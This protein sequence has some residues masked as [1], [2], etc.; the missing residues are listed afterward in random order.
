M[1]QSLIADEISTQKEQWHGRTPATLR[2]E[3]L[4]MNI[5]IEQTNPRSAPGDGINYFRQDTI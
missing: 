3:L 1:V 2:H 5:L 4:H